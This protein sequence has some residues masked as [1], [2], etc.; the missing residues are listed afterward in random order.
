MVDTREKFKGEEAKSLPDKSGDYYLRLIENSQDALYLINTKTGNFEYV[1]PATTA[2]DGFTPQEKIEM[3]ME[4]I[5]ERIHPDDRWVTEQP[6][7]ISAR[8]T[9]P[10]EPSYI[11]IRFKHKAG[12]YV[13]LGITRNFVTDSNGRIEAVIGSVRDITETKQLQQQL[14]S[15]LDNY[16]TLYNRARVMLCRTRIDDGKVLE[17]N[18]LMAKFMG[19]HSR[20][21]CIAKAYTTRYADPKGRSELIRLLKEKGQVDNFEFKARRITGETVWIKISA[22]IYPEK[23]YLEGALWD[24]TPYKILTRAENRI[25][26]LVMQ[27]KSSKEIAFQLKRSVRTIEYHRAHIMQKLGAH[28]LVELTRRIVEC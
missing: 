21:E 24:I 14:E 10:K 9:L 1:S 19:F 25:L 7:A 15:A 16:K 8:K 28:N 4:G 13:W 17:C 3:G 2:I 12:H 5:S 26:G 6:K 23:G 20:E 18:E 22:R 27:G 11:E